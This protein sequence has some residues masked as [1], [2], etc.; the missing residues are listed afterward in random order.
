MERVGWRMLGPMALELRH[1]KRLVVVDAA[2]LLG[3][4][5]VLGGVLAPNQPAFGVPPT[6]VVVLAGLAVLSAVHSLAV[7]VFFEGNVG[8]PLQ[9]MVARN[10]FFCA[11]AASLLVHFSFAT[12]RLGVAVV[13]AAIAALLGL[14]AVEHAASK[15]LRSQPK[16]NSAS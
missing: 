2:L 3:V 1:P 13:V 14:T 5:A 7:V 12:T 11:I 16:V 15:W 4:A 9:L 6:M 10:L 8:S